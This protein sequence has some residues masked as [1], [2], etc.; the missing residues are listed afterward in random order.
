[1]ICRQL[2]LFLDVANVLISP[3]LFTTQKCNS[4]FTG[5]N[6]TQK[7]NHTA[8]QSSPYLEKEPIIP[9]LLEHTGMVSDVRQS[10]DFPI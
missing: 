3:N 4:K 6:I 2:F 9:F 1:M 5:L 7:C 8:L 10:M